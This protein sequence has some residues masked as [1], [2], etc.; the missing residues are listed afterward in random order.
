MLLCC[1]LFRIK[2]VDET[3]LQNEYQRMVEGL[4]EANIARETDLVLANP[5][6]VSRNL[7][8]QKYIKKKFYL[9]GPFLVVH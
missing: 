2:D 8:L 6:K 3:R 4:R 1:Y 9:A 7:I 5:G